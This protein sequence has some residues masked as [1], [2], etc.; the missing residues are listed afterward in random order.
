MSKSSAGAT[1][2][3]TAADDLVLRVTIKNFQHVAPYDRRLSPMVDDAGS[4]SSSSVDWDRPTPTEFN[5]FLRFMVSGYGNEVQVDPSPSSSSGEITSTLRFTDPYMILSPTIDGRVGAGGAGADQSTP[6]H[7]RRSMSSIVGIHLWTERYNGAG[8]LCSER[9]ATAALALHRILG[10]D[11]WQG[12]TL[13]R[14]VPFDYPPPGSFRYETVRLCSYPL[15]DELADIHRD[16]RRFDRAYA[17]R[18]ST[19]HDPWVKA[20]LLLRITVLSAPR[21]HFQTAKFGAPIAS[22]EQM[23]NHSKRLYFRYVVDQYYGNVFGPDNASSCGQSQIK[24]A[25]HR[26]SVPKIEAYHVPKFSAPSGYL[27][28]AGAYILRHRDRPLHRDY[29]LTLLEGALAGRPE[30]GSIERFEHYISHLARYRVEGGGGGG[31]GKSTAT[32]YDR[33]ILARTATD[34]L[35]LRPIYLDVLRVVLEML[36]LY[37]T[38]LPYMEDV[39]SMGGADVMI[40]LAGS[41]P[42]RQQRRRVVDV[43]RFCSCEESDGCDC[44]DGAVNAYEYKLDLERLNQTGQ[45]DRAAEQW[46]AGRRRR[47]RQG[48]GAPSSTEDRR[49]PANYGVYLR[50]L[51][52]VS[53][54]LSMFSAKVCRLLCGGDPLQYDEDDGT[55]HVATMLITRPFDLQI[56]SGSDVRPPT[57]T[58]NLF[59]THRRRYEYRQGRLAYQMK[60]QRRRLKASDRPSRQYQQLAYPRWLHRIGACMAEST[61]NPDPLQFSCGRQEDERRRTNTALLTH[62]ISI[63]TPAAR[64][65][66]YETELGRQRPMI[67]DRLTSLGNPLF[68]KVLPGGDGTTTSTFYQYVIGVW[69]TD[70]FIDRRKLRSGEIV[71]HIFRYDHQAVADRRYRWGVRF[72]DINRHALSFDSGRED[73]GDGGD[74]DD[75]LSKRHGR[76]PGWGSVRLATRALLSPWEADLCRDVVN[77]HMSPLRM[78]SAVRGSMFGRPVG[79]QEASQRPHPGDDQGE[80]SS[81]S[82]TRAT[83]GLRG[84]RLCYQEVVQ[85]LQR[86]VD[87]DA[88]VNRAVKQFHALSTDTWAR[89][90]APSKYPAQTPYGPGYSPEIDPLRHYIRLT[91]LSDDLCDYQTGR[92]YLTGYLARIKTALESKVFRA[93]YWRVFPL[94]DDVFR[95]TFILY[96]D[97]T[98][99]FVRTLAQGRRQKMSGV[100][101]DRQAGSYTV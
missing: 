53:D 41:R 58:T 64:R 73:G 16:R 92:A 45:L 7:L 100:S 8:A 12:G 34:G 75:R 72:D 81:A 48:I 4:S 23:V 51:A 38:S 59:E 67:V 56:S 65:A 101:T 88:T 11:G 95:T 28:P 43:E 47:R 10:I 62:F 44:E 37:V 49:R 55:C 32:D 27:L 39:E 83:L 21:F 26:P 5:P 93:L 63:T 98:S 13:G 50:A 90:D 2:T 82:K 76:G 70:D 86:F 68:D 25:L 97:P 19:I 99:W 29:A 57:S 52:R 46:E 36:T 1:T 40:G 84:M 66:L 61:A 35:V 24:S 69:S 33:L 31:G 85:R 78:L 6:P 79:R 14:A 80:T 91:L 60:K 54:L 87:T 42:H 15:R 96:Y 3:A 94:T 17:Y 22:L 77:Q 74:D 71:D 30:V 89:R 9:S 20:T 18:R